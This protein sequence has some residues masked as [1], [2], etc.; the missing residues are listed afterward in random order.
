MTT[1]LAAQRAPQAASCSAS[2]ARQP[3][4]RLRPSAATACGAGSSSGVSARATATRRSNSATCPASAR[5]SA[6]GTDARERA[7]R[8]PVATSRLRSLQH[9]CPYPPGAR[10]RGHVP[11]AAAPCR[12]LPSQNWPRALHRCR[13]G[14]SRTAGAARPAARSSN[15]RRRSSCPSKVMPA[16]VRCVQVDNSRPRRRSSLRV[17]TRTSPSR[18]SRGFPSSRMRTRDQS[19]TGTSAGTGG[20]MLGTSK[21]PAT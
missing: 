8:R 7:D 5:P 15:D 1:S 6:A 13:R 10:R 3:S 12:G 17:P 2:T 11:A 9:S 20:S 21:R 18:S 19:A 16:G 14:L 4:A